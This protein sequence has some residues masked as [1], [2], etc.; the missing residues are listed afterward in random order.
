MQAVSNLAWAFAKLEYYSYAFQRSALKAYAANSAGYR[1]QEVCNLLW[2]STRQ[3]FHP[4]VSRVYSR[5]SAST[6][7]RIGVRNQ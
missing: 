3:R 1:I 5:D 4:E 6:E 7:Q 2:A